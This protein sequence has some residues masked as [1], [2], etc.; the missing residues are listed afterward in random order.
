MANKETPKEQKL[1]E[2]LLYKMMQEFFQSFHGVHHL[3]DSDLLTTQD[4]YEMFQEFYPA[5]Y[6][7]LSIA[8]FLGNHF[9]FK[10][11]KD[12]D[13]FIWLIRKNS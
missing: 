3:Q 2:T 9:I 4:I 12:L 7:Q 11:S 8:E 6:D 1:E 5:E 13:K 10:Y